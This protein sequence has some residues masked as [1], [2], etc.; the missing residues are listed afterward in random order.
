[1]GLMFQTLI[2]PE[3]MNWQME[4]SRKNIGI[5]AS[6]TIIKYGTKNAPEIE[7]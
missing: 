6:I 3:D 5:P 7:D 4:T 2:P 1:M